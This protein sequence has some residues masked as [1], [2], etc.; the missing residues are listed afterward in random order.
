MDKVEEEKTDEVEEE[1]D[2]E[3]LEQL[4]GRTTLGPTIATSTAGMSG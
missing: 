4:R 2:I 1:E 3:E